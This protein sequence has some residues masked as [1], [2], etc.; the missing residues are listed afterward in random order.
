MLVL[1]VY[2]K[3]RDVTA[4]NLS[5]DVSGNPKSLIRVVSSKQD[6]S[7]NL[8]AFKGGNF[9]NRTKDTVTAGLK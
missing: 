3:A 2:E 4:E 6:E 8:K 7:N 1:H 5:N 9:R